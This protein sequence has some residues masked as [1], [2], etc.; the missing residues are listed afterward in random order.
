MTSLGETLRNARETKGLSIESIAR[1]TNI[2]RRYLAALESE[3]FSQFPAEAYVLGFLKNYA[4]FLGL[5]SGELISLF[6]MIK[7]QEQ[8]IPM[9]ELL[10]KRTGRR[11]PLPVVIG[12]LAVLAGAGSGIYFLLS[13]KQTGTSAEA[14]EH[15]PTD[16]T[17]DAGM[18]EQRFYAGDSVTVPL[19]SERYKF[20]LTSLG[21]VVTLTT[22]SGNL[23]LDLLQTVTVDMNNDG[24]DELEISL[25]DYSR[26]ASLA[27]AWIRF[28][29]TSGFANGFAA[30]SDPAAAAGENTAAETPAETRTAGARTVFTSG[31]PYPFTLQAAFQGYCMFRWEILREAGR[32]NRNEQYYARGGELN[33]QAQNGI[34]I[35]VSNAAAVKIQAIGGGR[36]QPVELGSPGEVVVADV[37]WGRDDAGG[38][39]LAVTRLEQ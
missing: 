29:R 27:G 18:L 12:L 35:W 38:W 1:E 7:L 15:V 3:D 23:I 13:P 10:T 22:P 17:L 32:Q 11:K 6:K 2:A 31:T 24:A 34:R 37:A 14:E 5:N 20:V 21:E 25:E 33:I 8:P 26:N 9:K 19:G 28:T 36:T 30:G 39:R 4:D 16:Y